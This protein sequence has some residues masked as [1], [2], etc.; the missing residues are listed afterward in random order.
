M[1][2]SAARI[3]RRRKLTQGIL[4]TLFRI[5]AAINGI[6]LFVI[7]FFIVKNG[8]GAISWTF[9]TEAPVDSMTRG[10]IFPCIVGTLC[11]GA[12]AI[13]V[14][15]PIGVASAI[16][17]NEYSRP[18]RLLRLIRLGINNLAGVPSVVFGLFGLAF[19][20][21]VLNMGVSILAGALT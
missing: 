8:I 7:V 9:L 16:Y 4:F 3:Q 12:G 21:I 5:T 2:Q 1:E 10:G 18:G 19:F 20:C 13:A 17:I 11:L 6:A 15:L 14:A